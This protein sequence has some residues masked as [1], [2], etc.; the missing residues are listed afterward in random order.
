MNGGREATVVVVADQRKEGRSLPQEMSFFL[1]YFGRNIIEKDPLVDRR[2]RERERE[3]PLQ[4]LPPRFQ[5]QKGASLTIT[6]IL[7]R[8]KKIYVYQIVI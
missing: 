7:N 5:R 4:V 2:K 3:G 6:L 8:L 1:L